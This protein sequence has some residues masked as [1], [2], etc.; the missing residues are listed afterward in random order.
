MVK[1]LGALGL[2]DEHPGVLVRQLIAAKGLADILPTPESGPPAWEDPSERSESKGSCA[3]GHHALSD[4]ERGPRSGR[5]CG[6]CY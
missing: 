4:P 2:A 6:N 3:L 1:G 5:P